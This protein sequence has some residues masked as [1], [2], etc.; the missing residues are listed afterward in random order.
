MCIRTSC[1]GEWEVMPME[2]RM[3]GR[4]VDTLLLNVYY[5]DA[6][7]KPE[8][9]DLASFLVQQLNTWKNKAI[10][11][12]EPVVVPWVFGGVHLQ[13]Y[14][15][16]AGRGQWTWLLTSDLITLCV[17]RGRLNCIALVRCSSEYLWSCR[18]L[19]EAIEQ[20]RRFLCT[21]FETRVYLQV[22]EVHLCADLAWSFERVDYLREFVSRSRK[23]A[24]YEVADGEVET[25]AY[26]WHRTGLAF[27]QHG[28]I[29]C[30]MY[31]KAREIKRSGK[32]WFEDLWHSN[33][34]DGSS[35]VW[36]VEFRFKREFLHELKVDGLYHGVEDATGLPARLPDLWAYAAG[37]AQGGSDGFPDGWLRLVV[38]R[39]DDTN[40]SR[41]PTHP[42]WE[43]AQAAFLAASNV[44]EHFHEVIRQRKQGWNTDRAIE[45]TMGFATS[46]AAHVGGDLAGPDTDFSQFLHWLYEVGSDYLEIKEREFALE[47]LRKRVAFGLQAVES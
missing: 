36:R 17:S 13:M 47:V 9:R 3:V 28:P 2:T 37:H 21:I 11:V 12:E 5:T 39:A 20:V 7:G 27:S 26:G 18:S 32:L 8:K 31:D 33:G 40:R 34:W 35:P 6:D 15:H 29:S 30:S 4:G 45:S 22:S 10:A 19:Q 42:V 38:P 16:G 41:W 43:E 24:A 44:P 23:R 14:P 46:L 1:E 25:Y